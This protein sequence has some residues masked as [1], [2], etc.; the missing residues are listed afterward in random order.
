[1]NGQGETFWGGAIIFIGAPAMSQRRV[2]THR[3]DVVSARRITRSAAAAA[4]A[5]AAYASTIYPQPLATSRTGCG[6]TA[7]RP[8]QQQLA[9]QLMAYSRLLLA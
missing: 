9:Q 5:A 3:N 6:W 7:V 2:T 1:M 4:A 8:R